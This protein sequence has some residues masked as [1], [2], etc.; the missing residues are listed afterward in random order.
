MTNTLIAIEYLDEM[1]VMNVDL[2]GHD[3]Q[4]HSNQILGAWL[5]RTAA[6]AELEDDEDDAPDWDA[7]VDDIADDG[8]V[9]VTGRPYRGEEVRFTFK[10]PEA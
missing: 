5:K 8:T 10:A 6:D 2:E 9:T 7:V 3:P 4:H 1:S